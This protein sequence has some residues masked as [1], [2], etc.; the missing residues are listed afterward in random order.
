MKPAKDGLHPLVREAGLEP[1]RAY[2]T[3]EPESEYI[4]ITMGFS[5]IC[6][7][8]VGNEY[9]ERSAKSIKLDLF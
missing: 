9:A 2:C 3:L 1:A 4:A 6:C 5:R 7:A 8:Y